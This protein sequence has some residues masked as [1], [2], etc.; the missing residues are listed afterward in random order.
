VIQRDSSLG[1][2]RARQ[3]GA[4]RSGRDAVVSRKGCCMHLYDRRPS[5]HRSIKEQAAGW[6]L[7]DAVRVPRVF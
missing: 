1:A 2:D 3:I 6:I 7:A 5:W 4:Y